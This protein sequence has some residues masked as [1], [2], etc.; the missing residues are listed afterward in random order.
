MWESHNSILKSFGLGLVHSQ[1]AL[2]VYV[3]VLYI[4]LTK[5]GFTTFSTMLIITA[6]YKRSL[7]F[8][9]CIGSYSNNTYCLTTHWELHIHHKVQL[10]DRCRMGLHVPSSSEGGKHCKA[11]LFY[12][13]IL[14]SGPKEGEKALARGRLPARARP[15][16]P[17]QV[18]NKAAYPPWW[19]WQVHLPDALAASLLQ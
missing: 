12:F 2:R 1:H 13:I 9:L 11:G 8:K 3:R 18:G 16:S 14:R 19:Q 5:Y 17:W 6:G 4:Q 7:R 15:P 10:K